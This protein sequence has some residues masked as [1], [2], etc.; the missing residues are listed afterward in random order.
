MNSS[1]QCI[2]NCYELTDYF[3]KDFYEKD[4][5]TDNPLG[6]GGDLCRAYSNLLKNMWYGKNISFSPWAF[7]RSISGFQS[8]FSGYQQHDTQEFLNYVLDGLHEDLNRVKVKPFVAKD[9]SSRSDDL[10]SKD[11]W[12]GFLR[13]NQSILVDLFYG[14][15]KSVLYCPDCENISTCFD[16]FLSVSLPLAAKTET[17]EIQCNFIF[18]DMKVAPLR[19]SLQFNT[20]TTLCA[21]RNKLSKILNIHPFSFL[22]IKYDNSSQNN[23]NS[24]QGAIYPGVDYFLNSHNLVKPQKNFYSSNEKKIY[25]CIEF[26]PNVFY[27]HENNNFFKN[28]DE[29]KIEE[30][31]P[32]AK[33]DRKNVSDEL[34]NNKK[35]YAHL[36][37]SNYDEDETGVTS[38]SVTYYSKT[39]NN[40]Y[41]T[42]HTDEN[43]GFKENLIPVLIFFSKYETNFNKITSV[44]RRSKFLSPRVIYMD[45]NWKLSYVHFYLYKYIQAFYTN[46]SKNENDDSN[47]PN[48]TRELSEEELHKN[49]LRTFAEYNTEEKNDNATYQ[50]QMNWPYRIRLKK[51]C[52]DPR[53]TNMKGECTYCNKSDCYDC[54]FPY[55]EEKTLGDFMQIIPKSLFNNKD[56][57]NSYYY[58]AERYRN[59]I[60]LNNMDLA[61]D[62]SFMEEEAKRVENLSDYVNI[63][64]KVSKE[65][66]NKNL[67]VHDC[68]KNF[69]KLE[70]LEANNE[71][72]CPNCKNHVRATKKMEIFNAPNIL[73]I[74]LKRFKN[75]QKIDSLIDFPIE[76]L[77]I[78]E[79]VMNKTE[80]EIFNYDL[81]AVANHMG[82][83]GFGH[84]TAYA[85]NHFTGLW[86]DFD[87]SNVTK[88]SPDDVISKSAY[89]LFYRK[90]NMENK[91]KLKDLY[92]KK[93]E[94]WEDYVKNNQINK[95]KMDIDQS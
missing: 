69:V 90:K 20:E 9:E 6:S 23:S 55:S 8:M 46:S 44:S 35:K 22:V 85:K 64:F 37:T 50:K 78:S 47:N 65:K 4:I 12:I 68:F 58:L 29:K 59:Y 91:V 45:K 40:N 7:K 89:V 18:F 80:G 73:I 57:D 82:S 38:E 56:L 5:N 28:F 79:F 36:F 70:K 1:L 67:D 86:Y 94:D 53:Q 31:Y 13:R 66:S 26:D 3:L 32:E 62:L 24:S 2:S 83:M 74:H 48:Q 43:H 30:E 11:C 72:F 76:D 42:L 87:D 17:Y 54:L 92:E 41:Y 25:Y 63:D 27:S 19:I 49:F 15:F 10:K 75:N 71:W 77:D 93:Y 34:L 52:A 51:T 95:D 81:F 60:N 14:L 16:P 39:I 84:Y 33:K 21:V 88:V 61:F